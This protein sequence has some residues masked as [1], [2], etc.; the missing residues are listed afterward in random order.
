MSALA[1]NFNNTPITTVSHN[2]QIWLTSVE[3]AK[4]LGYSKSDSI[5]RI[6][7]RNKDEFS[8]AMST[9]LT[10]PQIDGLGESSGL[11]REQRIFSLRGCHLLA[12][13]SR[14]AI[15]KEFRKWVLDILLVSHK[16]SSI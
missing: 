8:E 14:T 9:V 13:F 11:Q 6:F 10:S 12:M 15:A 5:S 4:S 2:N 16:F 1:L 3:L 7:D